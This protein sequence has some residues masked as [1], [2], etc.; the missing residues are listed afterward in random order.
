MK[1]YCKDPLG[2][3]IPFLSPVVCD[4]ISGGKDLGYSTLEAS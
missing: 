4:K 2:G 1:Y 3:C